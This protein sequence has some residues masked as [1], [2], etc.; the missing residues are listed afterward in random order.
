VRPLGVIGHLSLDVVAGTAP[1]IGGGP[2]HAARALRSL[3]HDAFVFAKCGDRAFGAQLATLGLPFS[4][5]TGGDTTAFSFSYD[6]AGVRTMAVD[7]IGEPWTIDELPQSLLRRVSWLQLAPTLAGDFDADAVEWLARDRRI[8]LDG[9]G[10]VRRREVGPLQLDGSVDL[11]LLRHVSMLKLA[12]EE[13][14]VLGDVRELGVPEVLVTHGVGGATIVTREGS[15]DVPA[16]VVDADPTG[17]G[18]A[19][20]AAYMASRAEGHRPQSAAHRAAAL[21]AAVL[22]GRDR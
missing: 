3:R 17:A 21:V 22:S 19:F 5:I 4:L 12:S 8:M 13:A 2:W 7:A 18:D 20:A 14:A 15:E 9:Q 1:R 10:L 11:D 6:D 16:R